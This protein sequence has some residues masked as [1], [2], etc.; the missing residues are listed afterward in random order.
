M[1]T[2]GNNFEVEECSALQCS[3]IVTHY[4]YNMISSLHNLCIIHTGTG[5]SLQCV[6]IEWVILM[7][8]YDQKN[9]KNY[10]ENII[11][12]HTAV[13]VSNSKASLIC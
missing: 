10:T 5:I 9:V 7:V 8:K 11:S 12:N 4:S 13:P 2:P 6:Y 1:H 3:F